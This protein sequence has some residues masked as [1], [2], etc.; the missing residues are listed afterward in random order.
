MSGHSQRMSVGFIGTTGGMTD[1]QIEQLRWLLIQIDPT[2]V[3][4][5]DG[6]GADAQFHGIVC[7]LGVPTILHP[8]SDNATRALCNPFTRRFEPRD[9]DDRNQDMVN[10]SM[11]V[12]VAVKD[13]EIADCHSEAWDVMQKARET[14][15]LIV[16]IFPDGVW[17]LEK[18]Y[19]TSN[20]P[21]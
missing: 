20:E 17:E 15:C 18:S 3:H 13:G 10:D 4:H 19:E 9:S 5:R 8:G 12:I 2:E 6:L 14:G 11:I 7:S 1:K 21:A 16:L